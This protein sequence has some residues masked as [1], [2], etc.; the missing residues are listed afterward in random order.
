MPAPGE[1]L[2]VGKHSTRVYS[3]LAKSSIRRLAAA[4]K[5][6]RRRNATVPTPMGARGVPAA[7][8]AG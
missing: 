6:P 4:R 8:L 2:L 5:V 1:A 7:T 3:T